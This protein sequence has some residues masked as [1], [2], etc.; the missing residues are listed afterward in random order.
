MTDETTVEE[1]AS[2]LTWPDDMPRGDAVRRLVADVKRLELR[3]LQYQDE[4]RRKK[5]GIETLTKL[6]SEAETQLGKA[7]TAIATAKLE[8][9]DAV[10]YCKRSGFHTIAPMF[11]EIVKALNLASLEEHE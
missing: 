2:W 10:K 5:V 6:R 9:R 11:E 4:V 3:Q 1:R 7:R 8:A